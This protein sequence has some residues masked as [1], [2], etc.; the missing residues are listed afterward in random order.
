MKVLWAI[1]CEGTSIDKETNNIS[2]FNVLE[3]VQVPEPPTENCK[4]GRPPVAPFSY[5]I[6]VS[7]CRSEPDRAERGA[8]R[9]RLVFPTEQVDGLF[10]EFD[11]DLENADRNT[12]VCHIPFIP[13][14][15]E[16]TYTYIVE[17]Y[18]ELSE[19]QPLFE[20]PLEVS[21]EIGN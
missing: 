14:S 16:G 11:I 12:F 8:G 18:T 6:V 4:P 7:F 21:F 5:R 9:I 2:L 19:W 10:E 17:S 13:I 1:I 3:L 20:I 15:G